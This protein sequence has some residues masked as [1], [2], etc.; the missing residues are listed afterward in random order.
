MIDLF[1]VLYKWGQLQIIFGSSSKSCSKHLR[2]QL[3]PIALY[4]RL[5]AVG[6]AQHAPPPAST[7]VEGWKQWRCRRLGV[8]TDY[9]S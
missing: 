6:R 9:W 8:H 4:Y 3:I 7:H 2:L 1:S 5:A